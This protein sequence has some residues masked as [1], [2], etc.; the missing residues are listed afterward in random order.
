MDDGAC[1]VFVSWCG[2]LTVRWGLR[3]GAGDQCTY[4]HSTTQ[5]NIT[6]PPTNP[7]N[8]RARKRTHRW[9]PRP[10]W[11]RRRGRR[12]AAAWTGTPPAWSRCSPRSRAWFLFGG[13][14]WW[15][16]LVLTCLVVAQYAGQTDTPQHQH[17]STPIPKPT[18]AAHP[19]WRGPPSPPPAAPAPAT[20][21]SPPAPRRRGCAPGFFFNLVGL[22]ILLMGVCWDV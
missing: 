5:N 14:W 7:I 12:T 15:C 17:E 13:C 6:D 21:G 3:R 19:A 18:T 10:R 4:L 8:T 11:W 22:C 16:L 9:R 20:P 2:A 1:L